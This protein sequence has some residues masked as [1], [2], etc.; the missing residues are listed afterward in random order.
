MTLKPSFLTIFFLLILSF[1]LSAQDRYDYNIDSL[2]K[3][4]QSDI[5]D[6][7]R[8]ESL[9]SISEAYYYYHEDSLWHAVDLTNE[10]IELATRTGRLS[11]V[12]ACNNHKAK[13]L[14]HLEKLEESIEAYRAGMDAFLEFGDSMKYMMVYDNIGYSLTDMGRY[15]EA[16][17]IKIEASEY[18][19]QHSDSNTIGAS[20]YGL[21]WVYMQKEEYAKAVPMY[22]DA[23]TYCPDW[24]LL[25]GEGY[26]DLLIIHRNLGNKDSVENCYKLATE[27]LASIPSAL[28]AIEYNYAVALEEFGNRKK[29]LYHLEKAMS[30]EGG[31]EKGELHNVYRLTYAKLLADDGQLAKAKSYFKL[32]EPIVS[33]TENLKHEEIYLMAELAINEKSGNYKSALE[34]QRKLEEVKSV[35]KEERVERNFKEIET[36]YETAKKDKE[37]ETLALK[38][39]LNKERLAGRNRWIAA[40]GLGLIGLM[41][42]IWRIFSQKKVITKQKNA[43]SKALKER[44][45]LLKEIHHRVKN[46]LQVISSLLS[47]QSRYVTDDVAHEALQIGKSRVQ[48]MSLLHQKLYTNDDLKSVNLK[49]YFEELIS[50]LVSTYK[51]GE[52]VSFKTDIVDIDLD[53]DTVV[54]LG[55]ITNELISNAFKHAFN[56]TDKGEVDLVVTN[57]NGIVKLLLKDNGPGLPFTVIPA[58]TKSLGM[59]L[60]K[61]FTE[62][63]DGTYT[64]DNQNGTTFEIHFPYKSSVTRR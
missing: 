12:G 20:L 47:L 33:G 63:L 48:S 49:S 41:F 23:L 29:A 52:K 26:S 32:A 7:S 39:E 34:S 19:K 30:L 35:G 25:V 61:S 58:K 53:I 16:I 17:K 51:V 3:V 11:W 15:D 5:P 43:L 24:K 18:F 22:E 8:I 9:Y 55:L 13:L 4:L 6:S 62:K 10:C 28:I 21:G 57:E 40:L 64:I 38:D 46:N 31:D 50:N 60:I 36:K 45:M 44:T 1:E 59:Q 37:I 54:P 2:R 27:K 56:E 42:F 14:H